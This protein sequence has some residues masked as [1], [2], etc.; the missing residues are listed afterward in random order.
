MTSSLNTDTQRWHFQQQ[1]R[2]DARLSITT[3]AAT[4]RVQVVN[5]AGELD[6]KTVG[7]A[8]DEFVNIIRRGPYRLVFNVEGLQVI[9]RAGLRAFIVASRYA[10]SLRGNVAIC[11]PDCIVERHLTRSGFKSLLSIYDNEVQAVADL[12]WTAR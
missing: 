6:S 1:P 3:R 4:D 10:R 8:I 11:S 5:V 2:K 7:P 12:H 9:T